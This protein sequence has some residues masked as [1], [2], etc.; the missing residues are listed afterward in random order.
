MWH[1]YGDRL[2]TH[3]NQRRSQC[4]YVHAYVDASSYLACGVRGSERGDHDTHL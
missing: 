2:V 4:G 1:T 3:C